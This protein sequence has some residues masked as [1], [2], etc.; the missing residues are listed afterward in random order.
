MTTERL[1]RRAVLRGGLIAL[2]SI[3]SGLWRPL[4]ALTGP[5]VTGLVALQR[6]AAAGLVDVGRGEVYSSWF[7]DGSYPAPEIRAREGSTLRIALANQLPEPTTIHWHG[8]P[9]PN[10]MDGVPDV[11]QAAVEPGSEFLYEFPA[12]PAGSYLYHSHYGLQLDRGLTGPLVIEEANPHVVWDRDYTVFLD[13]YLPGAPR[14]LPG[15][16]G[17]AGQTPPYTGLLLNGKLPSAAPTLR[18]RRGERV[19]LRLINGGSATTFRVAI[20]NHRLEVTHADGRPVVPILVDS[21]TLGMG[22]RVDVIVTANRPGAWALVAAPLEVQAVPAR[23]VLL[24]RGIRPGPGVATQVPAGLAGGRQLQLADLVSVEIDPTVDPPADRSLD[25]RLSGGMMSSAW[26]ING[27]AYPDADPID[28]ALGETVE[29]RIFNQSMMRHPMHLH[30]RPFRVGRALKDTVS[31]L[32]MERV[33][34]K[35]SAQDAGNWLF[36][37]HN[38]YHMEAGMARVIRVF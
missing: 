35:V 21:V 12:A 8:V 2:G 7:F 10:A 1:D 11:T 36:H 23:A 9:V 32:P 24:Y 4:S 20:T 27:Q 16:M 33:T 25:L 3:G 28:L 37:C 22:E 5:R 31:V 30:G 17:M 29:F 18:V 38:A 19:R 26:T 14:P 34:L 15:G 6:T 13:D